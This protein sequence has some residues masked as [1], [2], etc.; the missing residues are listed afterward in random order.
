MSVLTQG[1]ITPPAVPTAASRRGSEALRP[2]RWERQKGLLVGLTVHAAVIGG[3][4]AAFEILSGRYVSELT[5]PKP[6]SILRSAAAWLDQG[7]LQSHL[8]Y[9]L[10][11]VG[12]G[13]VVGSLAGFLLA[14]LF[15]EVAVLGRFGE[16]YILAVSVI[17][18]IALVPLFVSWLGLGVGTKIAMG[19]FTAFCVV[20]VTSYQGLR[21]VDARLLELGRLYNAS[22]WQR[23]VTIR[24]PGGVPH[25]LSGAKLALPK[26]A[27]AVVVTE[28]LAGNM[29]LGYVILRSG[30]LLDIGGMFVGIITLTISV[31]LLSVLIIGLERSL[32]TWVPREKR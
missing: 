26:V 2:G 17:P 22:R 31:H 13:F 3:V 32:L 21:A 12:I 19:V 27:L 30:N 11:T 15:T 20:F 18:A 5:I 10:Q 6:T 16:P 25:V 8:L 4:L 29:G 9:T 24:L 23:L 1:M 7:Y 28:Y 14:V